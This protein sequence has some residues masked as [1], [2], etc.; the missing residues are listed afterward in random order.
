[1]YEDIESKK[2]ETVRMPVFGIV[3]GGDN[4]L[5]GVVSEGAAATSIEAASANE[6]RGYNTA[7]ARFNMKLISQTIMFGKSS[8]SQLIYRTSEDSDDVKKF[9]VDYY[10]LNGDK[11]NYVGM[12]ETYRDNLL[13]NEKLMKRESTPTLNVDVIGAIDVKANFLGFYI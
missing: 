5:F 8:N 6:N 3:N 12:A 7:Y 1:M 11:A 9:K 2:N 10:V 4:A 13:S